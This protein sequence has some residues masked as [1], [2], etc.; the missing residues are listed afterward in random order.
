MHGR[1]V[2][3][4]KRLLAVALLC[5]TALAMAQDVL[6]IPPLK[7]RVIDQTRTL[8][9]TQ[10]DALTAKLAAIEQRFGTQIV[11]L[12]VPSTQPEDIAA[13]A[14]RV[15]DGWKIGRRE[16]GDGLLIVVAKD[17]RTVRIEVAKAL[18]GAVPDLMARR[19]IDEQIVP[20]FRVGQFAVG[21]NH[22]VDAI[23]Q[24]IADERLPQPAYQMGSPNL[25]WLWVVA[26]MLAA[27]LVMLGI[28]AWRSR[29]S[30]A[31]TVPQRKVPQRS[32]AD[33]NTGPDVDRYES[34]SSSSDSSGSASGSFSSGGGG[35]FGGGG[36]S[37]KW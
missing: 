1:A 5:L 24:R 23:E 14:Q 33:A 8:S 11:V 18:E 34:S 30:T 19:I 22:A 2:H 7:G 13:Y 25:Q 35:D 36:A 6:P 15:G 29:R 4:A 28:G 32:L 16:V 27:L 9:A 26:A 37:G 21:L 20:L 3:D 12:L 31:R 10:A 17:D